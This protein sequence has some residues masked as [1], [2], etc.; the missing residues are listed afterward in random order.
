MRVQFAKTGQA[1]IRN[2][3]Y[4]FGKRHYNLDLPAV[5]NE[6]LNRFQFNGKES[7]FLGYL[8]Y[9]DYGWRMH[10]PE[11]GR[12]FG[13][14][15]LAEKFVGI[16]PYVYTANNP[17]RYIDPNGMVFT[18]AAWNAIQQLISDANARVTQLEHKAVTA[19]TKRSTAG[20]SER[21]A[22][23]LDNRIT[24]LEG[25]IAD[26]KA[27]LAEINAL[28]SAKQVYDIQYDESRNTNTSSEGRLGF[29]FSTGIATIY[30][31]Y[32]EGLGLLAHELKHA[33]QFQTGELSLIN[34]NSPGGVNLFYDRSDEVAAY[35]RG[36][37]F[38]QKSYGMYNL[39]SIYKDL[40]TGPINA[41]NHPHA[42]YILNF[43]EALQQ[44]ATKS[45]SAVIVNG[46]TYY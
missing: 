37:M 35:D 39:P 43:P 14:D 26:Y 34:L 3:Y 41:T 22:G 24:R 7:Q 12:W 45:R 19:R 4:P 1:Y 27:I 2:D 8:G 29:D 40:S 38:G 36:G 21:K 42:K 13:M 5:P 30:L 25:R 6:T 15:K 44:L 33:Y 31:P 32:G 18:N 20:I 11:I 17:V 9:L 46:V 10:D 23:R 16:S 28:E